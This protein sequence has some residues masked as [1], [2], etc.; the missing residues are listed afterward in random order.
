MVR[1]ANDF[2]PTEVLTMR[3]ATGGT[4]E[5]A[6]AAGRL[7]RPAVAVTGPSASA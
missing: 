6:L 4:V 2:E 5:T 1:H 3:K 7:E